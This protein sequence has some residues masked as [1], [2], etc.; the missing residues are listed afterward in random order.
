MAQSKRRAPTH[1]PPSLRW[2]PVNFGFMGAGL[3]SVAAG[4]FLLAGE[5]IV[6]APLLLTLGYV[7]LIPLGIIR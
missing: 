7:V 4:F 6:A 2:T 3:A 1:R 5:S